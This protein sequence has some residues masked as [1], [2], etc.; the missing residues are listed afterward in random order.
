MKPTARFAA[1]SRRRLRRNIQLLPGRRMK[2]VLD[3]GQCLADHFSIRRLIEDNFEAEVTRALDAEDALSKL[4][5]GAYHLVLVNRVVDSD[6]GYGVDIIDQIKTDPSLASVPVMLVTNFLEHQQE[7]V[8]A[9]AEPG[10]GKDA[11][12]SPET[13]RLLR[14]FLA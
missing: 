12:A 10:F 9:G 8:E 5:A 4:R 7:A 2:Q 3:V 14:R 1:R 13:H 6:G 11:L